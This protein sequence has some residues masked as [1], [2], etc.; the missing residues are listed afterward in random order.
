V[1]K[2]VVRFFDAFVLLPSCHSRNLPCRSKFYLSS[3]DG[4]I[5]HFQH[6]A[7]RG[8][9]NP[10]ARSSAT[11]HVLAIIDPFESGSTLLF[12]R[13]TSATTEF[14]MIHIKPKLLFV[15][16]IERIEALVG[17]MKKRRFPLIGDRYLIDDPY[18][19]WPRRVVA[20][21]HA[22]LW[23][24]SFCRLWI[25]QRGFRSNLRFYPCRARMVGS[26][27]EFRLSRA[28]D[29]LYHN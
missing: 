23:F 17:R 22:E 24:V 29:S 26:S 1:I 9:F 6:E 18:S 21:Y 5:D 27:G 2:A 25:S 15:R 13:M 16:S 14:P 3:K 7:S 4:V 10:I 8:R 12:M 20:I 19:Q 11:V 28:L